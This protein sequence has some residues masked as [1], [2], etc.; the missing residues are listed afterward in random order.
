MELGYGGDNQEHIVH[1]CSPFSSLQTCH[2]HDNPKLES[3]R[4]YTPWCVYCIFVTFTDM[5]I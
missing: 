4:F 5:A 1:R 3:Y 2:F